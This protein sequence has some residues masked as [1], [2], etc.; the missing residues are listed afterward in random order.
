MTKKLKVLVTGATG[1][2]GGAVANA[3]LE[4]GHNVRA[5]SRNPAS[6]SARKL[7]ELGAE[8]V[9]GN[10]DDRES[11]LK[12]LQDVDAFYLMG[13]PFERGADAEAKQ[14]IELAD[15]AK[16][17]KVGHLV[18][19][20]VASADTNTGIPHFDSKY[21]IE[22]H[23]R[24]LGTPYTISAPVFFMDN[25]LA[26]WSIDSLKQGKITQAM[27]A[28]RALQQISVKNIGEF[29]ASLI[30]RRESVFGH[31]F[32]I[33]GDELTGFDMA[34]ILSHQAVRQITYESFPVS[35]LKRQNSDMG[36]M[37]EWFDQCGYSVDVAMLRRE[38]PDVKWQDYPTW[39]TEQDWSVL[40]D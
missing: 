4:R 1:N 20:S 33:A 35:D 38:F 7:A 31:R 25:V 24:T 40:D 37:F 16:S 11:V 26:P 3:L 23:I 17:A 14:G 34:K 5:L 19:G 18:Y 6:D 27:P 22:Q 30:E 8:V 9:S 12:A 21:K 28:E 39:A 10:F 2:Q 29:V 36:A 15:L 32:D 13:S